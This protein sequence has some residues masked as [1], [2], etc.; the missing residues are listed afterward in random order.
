MLFKE[1]CAITVT[2]AILAYLDKTVYIY[3]LLDNV[4]LD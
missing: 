4:V 3:V 2:T 1:N